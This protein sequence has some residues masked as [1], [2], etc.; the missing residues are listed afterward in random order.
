MKHLQDEE[1]KTDRLEGYSRKIQLMN[2]PDD[3]DPVNSPPD[4]LIEWRKQCV[5]NG[6][7]IWTPMPLE[8]ALTNGADHA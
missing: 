4:I 6:V 8:F 1:N 5:E 7:D 3:F 2:P